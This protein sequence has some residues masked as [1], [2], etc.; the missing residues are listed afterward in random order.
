MSHK[1]LIIKAFAKAER[2]ELKKGKK[3]PSKTVIATALS[4]AIAEIDGYNIGEKRLRDYYNDA[5]ATEKEE[6]IKIPQWDVVN[7]LLEYLGF[8]NYTDFDNFLKEGENENG[9][10]TSGSA[11]NKIPNG[12]FS[13]KRWIV[14]NKIGLALSIL[15]ILTVLAIVLW[16]LKEEQRWMVWQTDHY[17]EVIFNAD[18]LSTGKLKRFKEERIK[19]FRK[20]EPDCNTTFF[21]PDGSV[22]I[23]YGKNGSQLEYF[24]ALGLHPETGK[25]LKAITP[26]MINKYVCGN[27]R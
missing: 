23:W 5:I 16:N 8:K 22:K 6:D 18:L 17:E 21:N 25:T 27:G 2:Q 7:A 3:K 1:K 11:I 15:A 20:V 12:I 19:E 13:L 26:Y 24:T 9:L 4:V 14:K 10:K